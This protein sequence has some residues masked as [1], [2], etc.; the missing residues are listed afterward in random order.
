MYSYHLV[1]WLLFF[2]IYCFLGWVWESGLVSFQ[3]K[4]WVNRGFMHGPF[5]PIYGTGAITVL[6]T[7]IPVKDNLVL[8]FLFG[9]TGATIL[10][11]CTGV[12][13]EKLFHVRYWDYS[14]QKFNLNGHICLLSSLAWG[15]FSIFMIKV[16]H[17][18]IETFVFLIPYEVQEVIAFLLTIIIAV[19]FTQSFNE[20]MDLKELLENLTESNEEIK[21]IKKRIEVAIAFADSDRKE[22]MQKANESKQAL[23]DKIGDI[24]IRYEKMREEQREKSDKKKLT[25]ATNLRL[26]LAKNQEAKSTT[27]TYLSERLTSYLDTIKASTTRENAAEEKE[28]LRTE[29][30]EFKAAI[31]RQTNKL[32]SRSEK[33]YRRSLRMLRRNPNAVSKKY[34]EALSEVQSLDKEEE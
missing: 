25:R 17:N 29:L 26:N 27:L 3:K 30:E 8:V 23:E 9:M 34:T 12:A 22:L 28:K 18:P 20:A 32:H 4:K 14:K 13:M 2:Y 10:E 21:K 19:D 11:Y 16:L 31:L 15:A 1:Q 7:T 6:L 33:S 5:L 24:K